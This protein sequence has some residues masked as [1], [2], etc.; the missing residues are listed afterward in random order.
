MQDL[1][2]SGKFSFFLL[3]TQLFP[4]LSCVQLSEIAGILLENDCPKVCHHP[5]V[6]RLIPFDGRLTLESGYSE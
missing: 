2:L 6:S 3:L 5:P 1:N 4:T